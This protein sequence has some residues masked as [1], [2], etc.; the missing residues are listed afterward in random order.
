MTQLVTILGSI[1][2]AATPTTAPGPETSERAIR[3][4]MGY[5]QR[6]MR[7]L[8]KGNSARAA[9]DFRRALAQ[10]PELPDAHAGLGHV[11]MQQRRFEDALVAYRRAQEAYRR[12]GAERVE[13]AQNRYSRTLDRLQLVQDQANLVEQEQRR[14]QVRGGPIGG[15]SSPSEGY[16]QRQRL[17]YE[18][19]IAKLQSQTQTA[20][21]F[22]ADTSDPPAAY[23]FYEA[24]A[25][26]NLKRN[27][28]AIAAWKLAV[29]RDPA[30]GVAFNNL[31]VA[32]WMTG[33]LDD[34]QASL[35]RADQLGFKVNPSFRAD[36][37]KAIAGRATAT[38]KH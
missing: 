15:G 1:F 34:A 18:Q 9:D 33:R 36:L 37:Q 12:F 30:Y 21:V 7:A 14:A 17:L 13:M 31:A 10:V 26:F 6:G 16:L 19:E 4:A 32:Y 23:H 25:L 8:E 24:N 20:P 28:E 35:A 3:Q 5:S 2:L 38:E 11:A 29:E 22:E 27:D